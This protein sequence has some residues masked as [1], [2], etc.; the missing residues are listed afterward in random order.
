M[1]NLYLNSK[2]FSIINIIKI[3]V[4]LFSVF[5]LLHLVTSK[6]WEF[7]QLVHSFEYKTFV[8]FFAIQMVLMTLNFFIEA[9]KWGS[10][11]N[12]KSKD[13][14]VSY[15]RYFKYIYIGHLIGMILPLG[16]GD[17][18]GRYN[19]SLNFNDYIRGTF[20]SKNCQMIVTC[21]AMFIVSFFVFNSY[22]YYFFCFTS[23]FIVITLVMMIGFFDR[24]TNVLN[25]ILL[26]FII[27]KFKL[28]SYKYS[29]FDFL[30]MMFLSI[31]RYL[32]FV[33]QYILC[34]NFVGVH[35][36]MTYK[37]ESI[38]SVYY[39]KSI[40]PT[41]F[42]FGIRELSSSYFFGNYNVPIQEI[43]LASFMLWIINF[44]IP[45]LIGL[46]LYTFNKNEL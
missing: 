27:Q 43:I 18:I 39:V 29:L 30:K 19:S 16:I 5:Y 11:I 40:V 35:L 45:F 14:N 25:G 7:Y 10:Y 36:N 21:L 12:E 23:L 20:L 13:S 22:L 44:I 24:I 31:I 46:V 17:Y 3:I 1:R 15:L 33:L 6:Y 2:P 4:L 28:V 9:Y 32:V 42:D 38:V 37:V 41:W 26:K 34:L 8:Y